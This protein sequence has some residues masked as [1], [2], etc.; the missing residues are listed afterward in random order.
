VSGILRGFFDWVRPESA[1]IDQ[2]S[3]ELRTIDLETEAALWDL[4]AGDQPSVRPVL[5][6][7]VE[8]KQSEL[9]YV[10]FLLDSEES[11]WL[12]LLTGIGRE[13]LDIRSDVPGTRWMFPL[14]IIAFC[15]RRF[16]RDSRNGAMKSQ[17]PPP[18]ALSTSSVTSHSSKAAAAP[19][20]ASCRET[21]CKC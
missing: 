2:D 11:H 6:L 18:L 10:F 8:C 12:P 5:N 16:D 4:K 13:W 19:W 14:A 9:P 3:G 21:V 7:L 17:L 1:F 20:P 15:S